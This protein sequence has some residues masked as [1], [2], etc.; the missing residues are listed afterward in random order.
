MKQANSHTKKIYGRKGLYFHL[1]AARIVS[2]VEEYK[3]NDESESSDGC[4]SIKI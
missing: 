1:H 3:F 2:A 4:Y